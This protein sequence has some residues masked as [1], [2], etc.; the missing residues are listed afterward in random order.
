M[1]LASSHL[2]CFSFI[3]YGAARDIAF[4]TAA[5]HIASKT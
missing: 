2:L 3:S 1:T 4:Q 5:L